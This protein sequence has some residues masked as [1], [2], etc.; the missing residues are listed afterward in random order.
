M[1]NRSASISTYAGMGYWIRPPPIEEIANGLQ[2]TLEQVTEL[3][4]HLGKVN[5][6]YPGS[7]MPKGCSG[8]TVSI[9]KFGM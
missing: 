8:G 2:I 1:R 4:T 3:L 6:I 9:Y 7:T 5:R